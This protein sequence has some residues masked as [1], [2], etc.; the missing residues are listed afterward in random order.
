MR[1]NIHRKHTGNNSII[2]G[3]GIKAGV[4]LCVVLF[5]CL[6]V[7][8]QTSSSGRI[9]QATFTVHGDCAM[10][11]RRI[12]DAAMSVI[13]VR[14]ARWDNEYQLIMVEYDAS[15]VKLDKVHQAIANAG[16]DTEK[17]KAS[18]KAYNSLP[19]CCRYRKKYPKK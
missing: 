5:T 12:E 3:M 14:S 17:I 15:L 13:G 7:A 2:Q 1:Q 10:C 19:E 11:K 8:A 9:K 6:S 16:H 18:R 4:M